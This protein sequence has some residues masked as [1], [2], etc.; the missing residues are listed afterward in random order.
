M[1]A[2]KRLFRQDNRQNWNHLGSKD[3]VAAKDVF[4]ECPRRS[5]IAEVKASLIASILFHGFR[6]TVVT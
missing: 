3:T 5:V 1:D 4:D 6:S 2:E